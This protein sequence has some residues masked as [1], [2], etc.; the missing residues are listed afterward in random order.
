MG[1]ICSMVWPEGHRL[2]FWQFEAAHDA[3]LPETWSAADANE[4]ARCA[5]AKRQHEWLASRWALRAGLAITEEVLYAPSGKPRLASQELSFS[6]C[7]P[8]AGVLVHPANAGIDIQSNHPKLLKIKERFAHADELADA[9]VS[10][11]ELSYVTLLWSAKEALFK[12]YGE[13]LP[14]AE[15]IRIARFTV[16][17]SELQAQV[18]HRGVSRAHALRVFRVLNHWVVVAL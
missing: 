9:A 16:G 8:L 2:A 3:T 15:G 18:T 13:D 10:S 17:Q 14:F 12:C 4:Y 11:D 7:L 6:H 1:L 5:H